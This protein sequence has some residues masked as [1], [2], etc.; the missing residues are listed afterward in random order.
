MPHCGATSRS[1]CLAGGALIGAASYLIPGGND[2]RLLKIIPGLAS[3]AFLG[4]ALMQ[5]AM[6]LLLAIRLNNHG[7]RIPA[8]ALGFC[9][10]QS[11]VELLEPL[12]S[13]RSPDKHCRNDSCNR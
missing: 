2:D 9:D 13:I 7:Y 10:W 1:A 5:L 12:S 11:S 4:Y 3:H 8:K 6:V